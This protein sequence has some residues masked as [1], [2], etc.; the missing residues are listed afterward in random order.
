MTTSAS[1]GGAEVD[2][3]LLRLEL[4]QVEQVADQA[5]QP[6][7]L[8]DDHLGRLGVVLNGAVL[9]G[10]GEATDRGERGAQVVGDRQEELAFPARPSSRLWAMSLM[11]PA[12]EANSG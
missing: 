2:R 1:V 12:S 4:G 5:F 9:D 6:P 11:E 8:G 3:D 7:R 10:L